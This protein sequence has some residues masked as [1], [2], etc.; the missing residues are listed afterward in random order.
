[1]KKI[2]KAYA[3]LAKI[4]ITVLSTVSCATGYILG[5]GTIDFGILPPTVGILFLA[6]SSC[7]INHIQDRSIDAR[8]NRT[9][10]RPLP[11]GSISIRHALIF[12]L[13]LFIVG[14]G[15]LYIGTNNTALLLGFIA[16]GWYNGVYTPLKRITS[17]AVIP[18]SLI[19]AI[20]PLV[21]WVASGELLSDPRI[22]VFS[23][24]LFIWQIP[25]FWLL[26]LRY[27]NDYEESG[28]P[29]LTDI[30]S[31]PALGRIIFVWTVATG[32][33][34]LL[35][36]L[37]NTELHLFVLVILCALA[38]WLIVTAKDLLVP[39][40]VV[41]A[42]T[43]AFRNINIFILLV[44]IVLVVEELVYPLGEENVTLFLE[45]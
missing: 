39:T 36:P 27:K 19:G 31:Q 8:M 23:F 20:P 2:I 4:R 7:V 34:S 17:L 40:R 35:M 42:F 26:L 24:L 30:F 3:E 16:L 1:M 15:I 13:A 25:H 9:R 12:A 33:V 14:T 28:L 38:F 32:I 11:S 10:T 21:G 18:G 43:R 37:Y 45:R 5:R 22:L 6:C 44:M 41:F 29:T